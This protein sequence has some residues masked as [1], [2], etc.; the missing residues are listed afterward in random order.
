MSI[1]I[2]THS[3]STIGNNALQ[4]YQNYNY[5]PLNSKLDPITEQIINTQ[6]A[7]LEAMKLIQ[8]GAA[9][10]MWEEQK[11]YPSVTWVG[12]LVPAVRMG[13]YRSAEDNTSRALLEKEDPSDPSC[14]YDPHRN[15]AIDRFNN[16]TTSLESRNIPITA[17]LF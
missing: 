16:I 4:A 3:L 6:D 8:N 5:A 7:A 12:D 15:P 14:N 13:N 1:Q 10:R 11:K 17:A 2:V 9:K